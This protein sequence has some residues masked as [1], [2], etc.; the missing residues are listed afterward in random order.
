MGGDE[1]G[2]VGFDTEVKF[3]YPG[4]MS[5]GVTIHVFIAFRYS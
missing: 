4:V 2:Y 3:R 1:R 5:H